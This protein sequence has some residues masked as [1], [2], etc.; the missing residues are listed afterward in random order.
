M[1]PLTSRQRILRTLNL[2]EVDHV[3]CCLMSFSALRKRCNENMY[4]L[5]KAERR[6]GLDSML[7][8]P[9]E[10]RSKRPENPDLRGLPVRFHP[11][12]KIRE[13]YS[14]GDD[15]KK[16][17]N[18]EYITP[19][20]NLT[21]IVKLTSDWPHGM[22]IPFLDDFQ[23]PRAVKPLITH[24]SELEALQFLLMPPTKEDINDFEKEM[25]KA[26]AFINDEKVILASG[27][28]VGIDMVAWLFGLKNL[29]YAQYDQP[30]FLIDMLSLINKWNISRMKVI[31]N[32]HVDL[33]LRRAW[34]EGCDFLT[35]KFFHK[36][37]LPILSNEVNLAHQF[38]AKFGYIR[39]SGINPLLNDYLNANVDVLI[40][41]DPVQGTNTDFSLIRK[42]L[43]G[44]MC[45]W[46]GVSGSI[47]IENGTELEVRQAVS[48]AIEKLGPDKFILSP[49]DN[50]TVDTLKSRT[51]LKTMISEWQKS[52]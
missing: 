30:D 4:E 37:V 28:G 44:N 42:K 11:D 31:L 12:V 35:P 34:Y 8:I 23:I 52:W 24:S 15:G 25:N 14:F 6:L 36:C 7:F 45:T 20:G 17:V 41:L 13:W 29:V 46:G 19:A 5:V 33:Y 2:E 47:T 26:R 16:L 38:G 32:N 40:G 10:P 49:V 51:N 50:I 9:Y 1:E 27:W 18:K 22:H 3:P 48:S 39:T 43:A 21:S